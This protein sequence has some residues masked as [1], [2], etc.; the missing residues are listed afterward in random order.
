MALASQQWAADPSAWAAA[1]SGCRDQRLDAALGRV[2]GTLDLAARRAAAQAVEREWLAERC[3][4]PLFEWPEVRQVSG[5]LRNFTP[6]AGAAD[7]WNAADWWLAP[8]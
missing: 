2:T 6:V 8:A 4:I 1:G 3:T 7:T 5:R